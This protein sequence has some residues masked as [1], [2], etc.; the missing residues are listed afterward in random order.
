MTEHLAFLENWPEQIALIIQVIVAMVLGSVLGIER[1]FAGKPA[2][3]RTQ[4]LVAGASA[5]LV[6]LARV[7][8]DQFGD[9]FT[10]QLIRSDPIRVMQAIVVGVSF[11]GAGTIFRRPTGETIEGLTTAAT[12]LLAAA[13][14]IA[15]ALNQFIVAIGV[16][17]IA[18]VVLRV[19][20]LAERGQRREK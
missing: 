4:M 15:C 16:T 17:V 14:G 6:G 5:L 10:G 19:L 2:G 11:L 8:V 9:T 20:T 1:E 13:L 3:F 12:V 18:L 7:L